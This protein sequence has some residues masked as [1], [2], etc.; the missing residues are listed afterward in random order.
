MSNTA[1]YS[2]EKPVTT[3]EG[4]V[5]YLRRVLDLVDLVA[6]VPP[7]GLTLSQLAEG[8]G[9]PISTASRLARLLEERGLASRR[10]D[11]RFVPGPALLAL[12]LRALRLLPTEHYRA[13]IADLGR[14]TGESVSAG[15]LIGDEI[16]LVARHE[17]AHP[18]RVVATIGDVI[19]PHL[20]AMGK[21]ILSTL[22]EQRRLE[23]IRRALGPS[24]I[25]VAEALTEELERAA[26][27]GFARDEEVFAVG[28]RCIA[29][30]VRGPGGEAH[31]ALS[32]AGPS[33]R[34]ARSIADS[35]VP[36]LLT[37]ARRVS[38]ASSLQSD[39]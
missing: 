1:F 26:S 32:V 19:A 22:S 37:A 17:S 31:G 7:E 38:H 36:D 4:S 13:A 9:M 16:V 24:G 29:A 2:L 6:A 28:L 15:V 33:T 3:A 23:I 10:P 11:K 25:A 12:G 35:C 5:S 27:E 34:F 39:A 20:S 18:L 30:P 21:A 14:S 8:T